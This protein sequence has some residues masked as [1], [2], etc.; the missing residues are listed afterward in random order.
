M[1]AVGPA[2]VA[3]LPPAFDEHLGLGAAA[4]PFAVPQF[5]TTLAVKVLDDPVLRRTTRCNEARP[6]CGISQPAH[7][8]GGGKF[9]AVVHAECQLSG[10]TGILCIARSPPAERN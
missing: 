9:G 6:D 5:V 10:V 1:R 8:L 3:E 2:L 4:E 7:N